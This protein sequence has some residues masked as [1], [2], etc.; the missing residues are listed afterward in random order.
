VVGQIRTPDQR[1]RVFISS[2]L[3]E[4]ADERR[5]ARSAVEQLRL[6]PVMFE[7][8]ARPHPPRALY[9]S[10]L[11]QSDVFVAIYWQ[12]YGWI[13]PDMEISGLED[14]LILSDG[15]P[16][17]VYV[18]RPAPDIEPRLADMLARLQDEDSVSYRPFESA[19]ELQG[20]LVDDLALLL[21]E[22]FDGMHEAA[23]VGSPS[24]A[25]PTA[26]PAQTSTFIG[27]Q[28][29]LR[30]V[31][32]L[33]DDADVRLIT[34]VGSGGSGKTRLAVQAALDLG[35]APDGVRFVDL[36]AEREVDDAF[37]AVARSVGVALAT[38][39]RAV[40]AL[41]EALR[42]RRLLLVLDNF[43]Q[44]IG[45]A[46]GVAELLEAC[47]G[48][49]ILVTSREALRVRGEH[50]YPVPPLSLPQRSDAASAGESEAVQL[51]VDRAAA[52][53]P[54]FRLGPGNAGAITEICRLL[55]GLPLAI[56]LAAARIRLFDVEGLR[57]RL[58]QHLDV[59]S[60][61]LRDL[62]QRQQTLRDAIQW[63]YDLL[64]DRERQALRMFAVFSG[65]R[66]SDLEEM[67]RRIPAFDGVDVVELIG[68]LVDK[69]LVRTSLGWDSGLRF[70]MLRTIRA[71]AAEQL[72]A[73]AEFAAAVRRA[74]AIQYSEVA[75]R[76]QQQ[77]G[78]ARR[79]VLL[80]LSD[81]LGNLRAAWDEWAARQDVAR[82]NELLAPLWGYYDARGDYRSAMEL[83]RK[84]LECLS[85]IPDSP[86]RRRDE[87][88]VRISVG[89]MELALQGYTDDA[90]RVIREALEGTRAAGDV[91]QRFAGLR[92]L[93]HVHVMR[94]DFDRAQLVA[95]EVMAIAEEEHDP[96]FLAEAHIIA[97]MGVSWNVDFASA[98]EHYDEA[99]RCADAIPRGHIDFRVGPHPSVVANAVSALT[100]WFVGLPTTAAANM[101]RA[102]DVAAELDHPYSMAYALHHASL[103]DLWREDIDV[104]AD[105]TDALRTLA[106]AHDYP[107]WRALATILGGVALVG[108]GEV[109]AGMA[110]V[111]DGFSLYEGL[112]TPPV[113][114]P[115]LLMIR[116]RA[117]S[118]AGRTDDA[119]AKIREAESVLQPGDPVEADL[120]IVHG[121]LMLA[122]S[123]PDQGA[124]AV[125]YEEA[126][127]IS[128][129]RGA[130][131]GQLQ[132]LTRLVTLRRGTS[133]ETDAMERL[134]ELYDTM[135]EG[136]DL[137][138]LR[139][140][141]AVLNDR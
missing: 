131:A 28:A 139:A 140:A 2:T 67:V 103:L 84:L 8:G 73:D 96:M 7:L 65:A 100:R 129:R 72:D 30:D 113:F 68:S 66:L 23:G 58:E 89:R 116:A 57:A 108:R 15:L 136:R 36:S 25:S 47:P 135:T 95:D 19:D 80:P 50:I 71:Y 33:L 86:E 138:H 125:K 122:G 22:R 118:G 55:D 11:E 17:L 5:A 94:T 31:R 9:R 3:S 44:A 83:G 14:E 99:V 77:V 37:A 56:E 27:R 46:I 82:L 123:P 60:A 132:A 90:E 115:A 111:D 97:G 70:S 74:H 75:L 133:D 127:S 76:L 69:S 101:Q 130:R 4:L 128:A 35:A 114:W 10:Y 39:V 93:G 141:Q 91:R 112:V 134:R 102:L 32:A 59:L 16:R 6:T 12:R 1:L 104:L 20:L 54:G 45:A 110:R 78:A 21:T 13:A 109:D 85:M 98:L 24:A 126:V 48:I 87:F 43:E 53:R 92:N 107:M 18:K 61:G 81:E 42:S 62:P 26:L 38:D 29:E 105:R 40:D 137:P 51:F 64:D 88:A 121:D 120:L 124:A 106:D 117:L 63:S 34:L 49:K 119:L 52:V 41:K 79:E